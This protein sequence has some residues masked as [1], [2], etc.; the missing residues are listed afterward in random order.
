M[1]KECKFMHKYVLLNFI[2][3]ISS[4]KGNQLSSVPEGLFKGL[5]TLVEMYDRI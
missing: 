4:F 1:Y 2:Y 5:N 3:F